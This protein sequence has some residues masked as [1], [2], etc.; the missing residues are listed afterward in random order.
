MPLHIETELAGYKAKRKALSAQVESRKAF[1]D[2]FDRESDE[3]RK[4]HGTAL[5]NE[6]CELADLDALIAR[7][8]SA[9]AEAQ[10][11]V[12]AELQ[13]AAQG[14]PAPAEAIPETNPT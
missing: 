1:V 6:E 7:Q 14:Q 10:G 8:E 5:A 4:L 2:N 13:K 12:E 9:V 3:A 11:K